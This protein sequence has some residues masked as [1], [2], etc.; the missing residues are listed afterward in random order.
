[1]EAWRR[2]WRVGFAPLIST[3]GLESLREALS[4]DDPR[5]IQDATCS[6]PPLQCVEDW[7]VESTCPIA[8]TGWKGESDMSVGEVNDHFDSVC[9][10][11]DQAI[12][13]PAST[14]FFLNWWDESPREVVFKELLAEVELAL[15]E[16]QPVSV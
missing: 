10:A 9:F 2:V 7:P 16:R 5:I 6:P 14:R 13:E 3:E 8:W 15:A 4:N 12:G 1:M 11:V